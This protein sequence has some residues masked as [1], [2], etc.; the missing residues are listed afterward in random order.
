MTIEKMTNNEQ[1]ERKGA[2]RSK[3]EKKRN[4]NNYTKIKRNHSRVLHTSRKLNE[5]ENENEIL[6]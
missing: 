4:F 6:I 1:P 3:K 5:N 2:K